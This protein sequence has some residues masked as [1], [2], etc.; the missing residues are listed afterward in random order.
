MFWQEP[1]FQPTL[2]GP[3]R[4]MDRA[5]PLMKRLLQA[6]QGAKPLAQVSRF[7]P[8]NKPWILTDPQVTWKEVLN[9]VPAHRHSQKRC[10]CKIVWAWPGG[11][12]LCRCL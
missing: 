8:Q 3:V 7:I 9:R 2:A 11:Q 1:Q 12:P 10:G 5:R 6:G 4:L